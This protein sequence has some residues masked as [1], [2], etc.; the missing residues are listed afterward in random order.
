[1]AF[2]F[3]RL[4]LRWPEASKGLAV[5]RLIGYYSFV[6]LMIRRETVRRNITRFRDPDIGHRAGIFLWLAVSQYSERN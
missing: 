1:M 4:S 3:S 5:L 6:M 2:I